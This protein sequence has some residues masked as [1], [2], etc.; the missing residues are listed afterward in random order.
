MTYYHITWEIS[1]EAD[2]P[3]EAAR[4]CLD[5]QRDGDSEATW[6]TVREPGDPIGREIDAADTH[7]HDEGPCC[8]CGDPNH[9][10]CE[11]PRSM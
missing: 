3:E 1:L 2:T 7:V 5:I 11:C 4:Y 6:F 8:E 9:C 10:C